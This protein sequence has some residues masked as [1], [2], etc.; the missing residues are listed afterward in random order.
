MSIINSIKRLF[1]GK[2]ESGKSD[3]LQA[4]LDKLMVKYGSI[5]V[6]SAGH[7]EK[8]VHERLKDLMIKHNVH[9]GSVPLGAMLGVS[10]LSQNGMNADPDDSIA[11]FGENSYGADGN[12]SSSQFV[13]EFEP[14]KKSCETSWDHLCDTDFGTDFM[15]INPATGL[16]MVGMVDIG[17][18]MYGVSSSTDYSITDDNS[19]SFSSN[20]SSFS[21]FD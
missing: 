15:A 19:Y 8:S 10:H 6:E 21:S 2:Q 7:S 17:G 3:D 18:N 14:I 12:E 5:R 16:L 4:R 13:Y 20:S 11:E 1:R 9:T